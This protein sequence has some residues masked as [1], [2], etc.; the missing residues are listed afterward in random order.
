VVWKGEYHIRAV[1]I[2]KQLTREE[3][4]RKR[5]LLRR[6]HREKAGRLRAG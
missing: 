4:R 2:D 1:C 6:K 5:Q 3:Q